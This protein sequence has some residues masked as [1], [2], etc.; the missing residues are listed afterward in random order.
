MTQ[1]C[2]SCHGSNVTGAARNG[3]P[4]DHNFDTLVNVKDAAGHIDSYAAS[5]P[6]K[7]NTVMPPVGNPAPT[8]AERQKLGEW[9]ACG[10]P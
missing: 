1:Y 3:A 4:S 5:G 6:A 10:A 8:L 2:A 9:L 7:T